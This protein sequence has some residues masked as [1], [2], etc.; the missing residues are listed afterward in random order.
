MSI[1]D[2]NRVRGA[3]GATVVAPALSS[4]DPRLTQAV[5]EYLTLLRAG[6]KPDRQPFLDRDPA[7]AEA[8]ADCLDA[9][10]FIHGAASGLQQLDAEDAGP[11]PHAGDARPAVPLGD[12]QIVREIGRGGMGVVY[13]ALQLSLG[14]RVALKILPFASALDARQ[15]QRFKHEAQTAAQLHHPHIVPIYAVGY[16]R[17]VHYYAMQFIEGKTL[18]AFIDVLR[19]TAGLEDARL[20]P[21]VAYAD[22]L[23][24]HP[25]ETDLS[26][27]S[28]DPPIPLFVAAPETAKLSGFATERSIKRTSF[29]RAAA[30]LGIQAAE[31]LEH[32]HQVGVVHRDVKPANLMVDL[33]GKLWITDFGLARFQDNPQLTITGDIVG[34]WRYMSPEQALA[35]RAIVDHRTDIYSL[36]VTLY[37]LLTLT[38][39]FNGQD[40]Q[41]LLRQIA[42]DDPP[43]PRRLN[44]AIPA[45]LETIILKTL[46]K[47][48]EERY[49]TARELADDLQRFLDD[50]PVLAQRPTLRERG[51]KWARR[52]KPVV[53]AAAAM[54]VL[55]VVFLGIT[56]VVFYVGRQRALDAEE[57]LT[58]EHDKLTAEQAKLVAKQK[59]LEDNLKESFRFVDDIST[60]IRGSQRVIGGDPAVK[61]KLQE[62]LQEVLSYYKRF[63][64]MNRSEPEV[65]ARTAVTYRKLGDLQS[66]LG[67][68]AQAEAAYD[69]AVAV[70]RELIA[71]QPKQDWARWYLADNQLARARLFVADKRPND[72]ETALRDATQLSQGLV[73]DSPTNMGFLTQLTESQRQLTELLLSTGRTKEAEKGVRE[74]LVFFEKAY[75]SVEGCPFRRFALAECYRCLG[76]ACKETGQ[77]RD[78][79]QAYREA[80]ALSEKN[81]RYFPGEPAYAL[82][83]ARACVEIGILRCASANAP[84]L[85]KTLKRAKKLLEPLAKRPAADPRIPPAADCINKGLLRAGSGHLDEAEQDCR[86]AVT[87]LKPLVEEYFQSA[88]GRDFVP[89]GFYYER[90][91]KPQEAENTYHE[92]A[93]FFDRLVTHSPGLAEYQ[94]YLGAALSN[95]ARMLHQRGETEKARELFQRGIAAQEAA[96]RSNPTERVYLNYLVGHYVDYATMMLRLGNHAE[97]AE[98]VDKMVTALPDSWLAA[99]RAADLL[100]QCGSKAQSD[101]RLESGSRSLLEKGYLEQAKQFLDRAEQ[102]AANEPAGQN[103]IAWWLAHLAEPPLRDA[104]RAL[105]L[106]ERAVR[107]APRKWEYGNTLGSVYYRVGNWQA[108]VDTLTKGLP[109]HAGGDSFDFFFL[110]MAHWHLGAKD[111]ARQWYDKGLT[112]MHGN[113][114]QGGE[115]PLFQAEAAALLGVPDQPPS[116]R[117]ANGSP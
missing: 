37:E 18:A 70:L 99:L 16:D 110:A 115:L 68:V 36:G 41:E 51:M 13:E 106:A 98:L 83:M 111:Q 56:T 88:T 81:S 107:A 17:G 33:Q 67:E 72:A 87:L 100:A 75:K 8:L 27:T 11:P 6:R 9:L 2:H 65:R 69:Q 49:A 74:S 50:K 94:S 20:P 96:F 14:R 90:M 40:R 71:D 53:V 97:A 101:T 92:A 82:Q 89:V 84:E 58:V 91:G 105:A 30:Q 114:W 22:K 109:L 79:E 48:P 108:A 95:Y 76:A 73:A 55:S 26:S 5:E 46:A 63:A 52:H 19:Q 39:A 102:L 15:L 61:Q 113:Q 29:V 44:N 103:D 35:K 47:R 34:T 116:E 104:K 3:E 112:W 43:A 77:A 54:L 42:Q 93:E 7:I 80:L 62:Q 85:E 64:E 24:S 38:P 66:D 12:Y 60:K 59:K 32:A 4:N 31:A 10:E 25:G 86:Q 23:P 78:S 28:P 21:T 57:K 1:A 117:K 45:E